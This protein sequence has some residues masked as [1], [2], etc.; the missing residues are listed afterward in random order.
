M[1]EQLPIRPESL[2]EDGGY[3]DDGHLREHL[4]DLGV[5][6]Y[7][8]VY[9]NQERSMVTKVGFDYPEDHLVCTEGKKLE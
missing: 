4:K 7:I 3:N 1:L 9:P 8:P 2:T 5:P 6:A